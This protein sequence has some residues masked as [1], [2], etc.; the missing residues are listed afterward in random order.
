MKIADL[1][2]R[3]K[4]IL[5]CAGKPVAVLLRVKLWGRQGHIFVGRAERYGCAVSVGMWE[6]KGQLKVDV[7][8]VVNRHISTYT[9]VDEGEEL[10]ADLGKAVD[11]CVEETARFYRTVEVER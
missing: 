11:D 2:K 3:E 4:L 8:S 7:A 6:E 1:W 10:L 9:T 5:E